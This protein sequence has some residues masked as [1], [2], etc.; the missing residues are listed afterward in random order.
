MQIVRVR[1]RR[2][3]RHIPLRRGAHRRPRIVG[4]DDASQPERPEE[5]H[6]RA[7]GPDDKALYTCT[8]GY[9]FDAPVSAS[10][11]CPHCG[12]GQAW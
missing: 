12:Q 1:L 5:R 7:G 11:Q 3:I 10:V 9:Q 6:R 4:T 2:D 8:C